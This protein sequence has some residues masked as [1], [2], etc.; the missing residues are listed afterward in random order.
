MQIR[1]EYP[2]EPKPVK[3]IRARR[4][5]LTHKSR[6]VNNYENCIGFE[7]SHQS[8]P[9]SLRDTATNFTIEFA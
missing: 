1:I 9:L 5:S 8:M 6:V 4:S 7:N 3:T 2:T